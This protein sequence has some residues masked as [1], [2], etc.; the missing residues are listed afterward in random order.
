MNTATET[1]NYIPKKRAR[2]YVVILDDLEF[3]FEKDKLDV[4]AE[5][6]NAGEW[7]TDIAKKVKRNEFETLLAIV[8][9]HKRRR[10]TRELAFRK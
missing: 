8:H 7:V 3:A 4:I 5:M 9:L 10:L 6:H 2:D 1:I